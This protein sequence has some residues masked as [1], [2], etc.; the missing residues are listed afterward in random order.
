VQIL[1]I[2]KLSEGLEDIIL[3]RLLMNPGYDDDPALN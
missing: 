3:L 1:D 2:A